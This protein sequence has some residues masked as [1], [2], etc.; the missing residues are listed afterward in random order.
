MEFMQDMDGLQ[1]QSEDQDKRVVQSGKL[2]SQML[3]L[4]YCDGFLSFNPYTHLSLHSK[5]QLRVEEL[6]EVTLMLIEER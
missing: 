1:R 5:L 6:R 3:F 2:L 4:V